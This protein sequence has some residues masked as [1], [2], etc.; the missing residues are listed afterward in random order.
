MICHERS[1]PLKEKRG[2]ERNDLQSWNESMNTHLHK[3]VYNECFLQLRA[4][5]S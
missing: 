2:E 5:E 1:C 4:G 3:K